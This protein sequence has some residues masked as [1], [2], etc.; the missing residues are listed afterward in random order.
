MKKVI[1]KKKVCLIKTSKMDL[2]VVMDK[3]GRWLSGLTTLF[4]LFFMMVLTFFGIA[5]MWFG[6]ISL[7]DSLI[8]GSLILLL[9]DRYEERRKILNEST[10]LEDGE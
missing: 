3:L 7:W 6:K 10:G 8:F 1:E 2:D 5:S 4:Y 9:S